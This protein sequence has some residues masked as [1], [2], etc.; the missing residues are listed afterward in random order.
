[1]NRFACV[2]D[3]SITQNGHLARF[4]IDFDIRDMGGKGSAHGLRCHSNTSTDIYSLLSQGLR[5]FLESHGFGR[6][7][8]HG[9]YSL[10]KYDSLRR[11]L[12][13]FGDA[14]D[15]LPPNRLAGFV[16]SPSGGKGHATPS[17]DFGVANR[18]G[19]SYGRNDIFRSNPQNLG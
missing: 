14:I 13:D 17:S 15:H 10:L 7:R 18:I 2:L 19:V 8:P 5:Q 3:G 1:M 9:E 4:R 16:G 6:I 11:K 12:P